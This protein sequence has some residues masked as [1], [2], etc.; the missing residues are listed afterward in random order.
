MSTTHLTAGFLP[1]LDSVLLVLARE[2]G[3]A[4]AE[5]IDLHLVRETSW[6]NIRDRVAIGHFDIAQMLAPNCVPLFLTDGFK[7]YATALLTHFGYWIQPQRRQ[8]K[9]PMPKPRWIP[10]PALLYA[11]VVKSYR[12]RRIV[13]VTPSDDSR[14]LERAQWPCGPRWEHRH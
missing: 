6:A 13:A 1:L 9:G 3:F 7:E 4:A 2:K 10:L 5:G 11:Q 14:A 12:R 8:D